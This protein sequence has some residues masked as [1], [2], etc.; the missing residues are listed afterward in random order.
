MVFSVALRHPV[1]TMFTA[2]NNSDRLT[3]HL[4]NNVLLLLF[5]PIFENVVKFE[6][7]AWVYSTK[8]S[9]GGKFMFLSAI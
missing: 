4:N 9:Q 8:L 2:F 5:D 7:F 6:F 3:D 1:N